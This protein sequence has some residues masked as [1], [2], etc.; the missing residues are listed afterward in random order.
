MKEHNNYTALG[1]KALERAAA[2]VS[3]NARKN[4]FKIPIWE[5]GRVE[6]LIPE[7]STEQ[8]DGEDEKPMR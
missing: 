6:Y 2:R 8:R 4:N 7:I 3:E 5:N 1:L